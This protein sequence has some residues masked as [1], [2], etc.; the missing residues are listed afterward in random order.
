MDGNPEENQSKA[1][2]QACPASSL[3]WS[4][5][6]VFVN[7]LDTGIKDTEKIKYISSVKAP[8][9]RGGMTA[10]DLG[11]LAKINI[12]KNKQEWR[13]VPEGHFLRTSLGFSASTH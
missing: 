12:C 8:R 11:L 10:G 2:L 9:P 5:F 4:W 7:Q 1:Q 3:A 6:V 13:S